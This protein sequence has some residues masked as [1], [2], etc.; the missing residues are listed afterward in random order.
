MPNPPLSLARPS[1]SAWPERP[2]T[3]QSPYY[4]IGMMLSRARWHRVPSG[5]GTGA[6]RRHAAYVTSRAVGWAA[7]RAASS[8]D[9]NETLERFQEVAESLA[10]KLGSA[11]G[12][13]EPPSRSPR[14]ERPELGSPLTRL[15]REIDRIIKRMAGLS[16]PWAEELGDLLRESESLADDLDV[17]IEYLGVLAWQSADDASWRENLICLRARGD[18]DKE[19][20]LTTSLDAALDG[21]LSKPISTTARGKWNN[22]A[23]EV[24]W[25]D[26]QRAEI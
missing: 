18:Q 25:S 8:E 11:R 20:E 9:I 7:I 6:K 12:R 24:V 5:I 2:R 19:F 15:T 1:G 14:R 22:L 26:G 23:V 16:E 10:K 4:D 17:D 3:E 13:R 21:F